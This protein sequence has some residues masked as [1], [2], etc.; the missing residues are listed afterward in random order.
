MIIV[1]NAGPLISLARIERF[2]L[3][4]HIL[5]HLYIPQAVYAEVVVQG[6]RK[7]GSDETQKALGD[8]INV[9]AVKDATMTRTLLTKLGQGESEAISLAMEMQANLVLLDD[10][11]ARTMAEFMGLNVSGTIGMLIQA[12]RK[13]L[14]RDL[15]QVLD[16]LKAKGFRIGD[17]VYS[18]ALNSSQAF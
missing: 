13:G 14:V 8:W 9:L 15:E 2:E 12:Y 16:E 1:S 10:R 7:A 18:E 17:G 5:G 3:L 6:A 11:K 4:R